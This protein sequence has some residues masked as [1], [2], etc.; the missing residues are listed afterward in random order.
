MC[1][2]P[3]AEA[4]KI[5][6]PLSIEASLN[7]ENLVFETSFGVFSPKEIDEG[8]R[9][10]LHYLEVEP[11]FDCLDLGCG[12]GPI[13]IWMARK[14]K[15]GK[16]LMFDKDFVAIELAKSNIKKN[17]VENAEA[18]LSNGLSALND[19]K[20]DLIV[21]NIPA[22]VGN[23]MLYLFLYDAFHHLKPGGKFVVV[24]VNGLRQ[25]CK[26]TFNEVFGNYKKVKQGK[27][28]TVSSATKA[29]D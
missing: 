24:T 20:F 28:Y 6:Q 25:F 1:P 4:Q 19:E 17:R 12:Y 3:I 7:G 2:S 15:T 26:R 27:T 9:L 18:R 29:D 21:S 10:L 8:T 11:G 13:G 23:E 5:R 14:S 16:V 22:K